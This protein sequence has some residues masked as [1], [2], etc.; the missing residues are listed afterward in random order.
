MINK[1]YLKPEISIELI[2]KRKF[3]TGII[4]GFLFSLVL[5]YFFNYSR[6][7]LRFITFNGDPFILSPKEFKK[8]DLFFASLSASIGFGI[9]IVYWF[10]GYNNRIVKRYLKRFAI[11]NALFVSIV[12]LMVVSRFG[13]ILPIIL[14]RNGFDGQ[15]LIHRDYGLLLILTPL[16]VFFGN[17]NAV[18]A[19]LR[20]RHWILISFAIYCLVTLFLYKTTALNKD[21]LNAHYYHQNR[22][23]FEYID[24]QLRMAARM[25]ITFTN[26]IKT[27]LQK[28]YSPRTN[29]LVISLKNA[30]ESDR[31]LTIDTLILEKIVI[32]N[33]N[34]QGRWYFRHGEDRDKNWSYA[35]PE[36][37]YDQIQMNEIGSPEM[38]ILFEILGEQVKL[39]IAE[40]YNW[41]YYE[42]YS[43]YEIE[44]SLYNRNI[45]Y[46]TNT[47]LSRLVQVVD[48]IKS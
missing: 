4:L 48:K 2:G 46:S 13:S 32:H 33:M 18:R 7:S 42:T 14:Y 26:D 36:D 16:Y 1:G 37:V 27:I 3:W 30:F 39:F 45:I 25:D 23:R 19:F 31:Q 35:L 6:E 44:L 22:E 11:T 41:E 17:W 15:L 20:T 21:N 9:A 34:E 8:Y 5:S 28:R 24:Q 10:L 38:K 43:P 47:I 12:V 40:D 29:E